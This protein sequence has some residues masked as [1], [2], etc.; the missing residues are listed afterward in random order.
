MTEEEPWGRFR[1]SFF[2]PEYQHPGARAVPRWIR[3][4]FFLDILS[5]RT[6][7]LGSRWITGRFSRVEPDSTHRFPHM[8]APIILASG[9]EIRRRLLVNAGVA[10][11]VVVPRVDEDSVKDALVA[12]GAL[13]RDVADAL[14]GLKAQR[15]AEKR[16]DSLVIGCDQ[17]L[18]L[19]RRL[20]SKANSPEEARTQLAALNGRRH[21]LH[22]AV[23]VYQDAR[24]VWRHVGE[25]RLTMRA[26]SEAY[27]DDYVARNWESIRHAVGS[28]KL[29]EEG[30]RLF[31]RIEGDYF[32]VLGLPLLELLSWLTLRGR[33]PG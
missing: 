6:R 28:Y 8:T 15:V 17:V 24:P 9:S 32:T 33:L 12:D 21:S 19:D 18:D 3:L 23:V 25:V 2:G 22:S 11:E 20:L 1:G 29:E 7:H 27:L 4:R 10:A 16:P 30:V 26:C 5:V 13:P 14:A 31:S